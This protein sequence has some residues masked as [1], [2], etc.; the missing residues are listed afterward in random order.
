MKHFAAVVLCCSGLLLT[1][2]KTTLPNPE[3]PILETINLHG[4]EDCPV[5]PCTYGTSKPTAWLLT[6]H[7]YV[8][9]YGITVYNY[10]AVIVASTPLF[11]DLKM[12]FS[13]SGGTAEYPMEEVPRGAEGTTPRRYSIDTTDDSA[14]ERRKW[15]IHVATYECYN[16]TTYHIRDVGRQSGMPVSAPLDVT[17][18][19]DS[20]DPCIS[21]GGTMWAKSGSSTT[22]S[23]GQTRATGCSAGETLFHICKKCQAHVGATAS[24]FFYE[25]CYKNWAEAESTANL[26]PGGGCTISQVSGPHGC[27][28]P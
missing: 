10:R 18:K 27:E 17:L 13:D 8:N 26:S 6:P 21:G 14:S 5:T 25:S 24:F 16:P 11:T 23:S 15:F 19:L 2:C 3:T 9:N 28:Q 4:H 7:S 20:T 1:S 12:T 22:P